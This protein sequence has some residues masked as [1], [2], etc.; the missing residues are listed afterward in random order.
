MKKLQLLTC[1]LPTLFFAQQ[2]FSAIKVKSWS[3]LLLLQRD[4]DVGGFIQGIQTQLVDGTNN[5][6]FG[7][8]GTQE[9]RVSKGDWDNPKFLIHENGNIGIGTKQPTERLSVKGNISVQSD[10]KNTSPRPQVAA[11]TIEGEIRGISVEGNH[12]DDGFLRLSAGGGSNAITKS[13]IDLSGYTADTSDRHLNIT[14]GTS[15]K[16][17][18]RI[19][20][21]GNIGIGKTNPMA[22]LDVNGGI[23]ISPEMPI[24]LN[25]SDAFHGLRYMRYN[26][27][28]SLLDG[29]FLY[30]WSGGALGIKKETGEWLALKWN[31]EGNVSVSNKLEAREIKV[32]TTPTADFVFEKTYQLPNLE[33]VEKHILEK[34]HLPEIASAA[35][36]QKEGVNIGEFQI[37][38]L[39]KIEELTLYSIEQ[40]KLNK[41]QTEQL[42]QQVQINKTLE[43]RLQNLENN[44]LKNK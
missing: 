38:L 41:K 14:M 21:N 4:T 33:D 34:K 37:K 35:E 31:A 15:G 16:E 43:Q 20:S 7:N 6:Y 28:N 25:G 32:T 3:P 1:L 23:N 12:M 29:P 18:L 22:K 13:F 10:L 36:M 40:N 26:S 17:R 9:W 2:E 42:Q 24:Q 11:G 30:G 8:A 44:N 19:D 39:Q 5:W 27:D